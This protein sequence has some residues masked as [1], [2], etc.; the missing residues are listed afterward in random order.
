MK[1]Y[2]FSL[3]S[4]TAL[5]LGLSL[6]FRVNLVFSQQGAVLG[7][8]SSAQIQSEL[9]DMG[10]IMPS[11]VFE[12]TKHVANGVGLRNLRRGVIELSGIPSG[13]ATVKAFL[14]WSWASLET[15]RH[16]HEKVSF[17]RITP[18]PSSLTSTFIGTQVGTGADPC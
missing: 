13:S 17:R 16:T 10:E 6:F 18:F 14:Y 12:R 11:H 9:S 3:F 8:A 4:L 1:R 5:I 7:T 15:P 2:M